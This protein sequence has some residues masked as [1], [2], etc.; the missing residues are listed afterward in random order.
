M[1][2]WGSQI[3]GIPAIDLQRTILCGSSLCLVINGDVFWYLDGNVVSVIPGQCDIRCFLY[4]SISDCFYRSLGKRNFP[5]RRL[6]HSKQVVNI[7]DHACVY[8]IFILTSCKSC[9]TCIG[10]AGCDV[11]IYIFLFCTFPGQITPCNIPG[12][13]ITI[14]QHLLQVLIAV[15]YLCHIV[16]TRR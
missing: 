3:K 4:I 15:Q 13:A 6:F 11:G 2:H 7:G 9:L 16:T 8:Q 1:K 14:I 5:L 12:A 10:I